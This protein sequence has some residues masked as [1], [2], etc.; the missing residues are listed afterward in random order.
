MTEGERGPKMQCVLS[1][2]AKYYDTGAGLLM[3]DCMFDEADL[4]RWFR[5]KAVLMGD[6]EEKLCLLVEEFQDVY[7]LERGKR[8]ETDAVELHIDTG[9]AEPK[10]QLVRRVPFALRK[11]ISKCLRE[12]M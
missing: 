7:S 10:S 2:V 6:E 3:A 5:L 12:M 8:G 1:S 11:E 9:E 4:R